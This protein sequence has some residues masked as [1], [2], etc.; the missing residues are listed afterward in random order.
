SPD[1]KYV[2]HVVDDGGYSL[3]IRQTATS[4]NVQIV[5]AIP[6][7]YIGVAFSPDGD[8]VFFTLL[9]GRTLSNV[10]RIP[11]LGG[12]PQPFLRDVDSPLSFSPDGSRVAFIRGYP[13]QNEVSVVI[14]S[15][16]GSGDQRRLATRPLTG[17]FP[18]FTRAAWSP[19]GRTIAAAV[20]TQSWMSGARIAGMMSVVAIDVETGEQHAMV[21]NRWDSVGNIAWLSDGSLVVSA[22]EQGGPNHQL[23]RVAVV[24][25]SVHRLTNDLNTYPDVAT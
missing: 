5:T 11:A 3:W 7:R 18:L 20:G 22:T 16:D 24:D 17:G 14:A 2:V 12:T 23:Y 25:G 15:A 19:D 4:S 9:E 1:G 21:S 13:R 6:D 8:Y 10:Y